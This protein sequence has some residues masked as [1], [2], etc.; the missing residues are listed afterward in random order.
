MQSNPLSEYLTMF[1]RLTALLI[2]GTMMTAC[3]DSST[4]PLSPNQASLGKGVSEPN[5]AV[6][7]SFRITTAGYSFTE[8]YTTVCDEATGQCTDL[9]S[10]HGQTG[11]AGNDKCVNGAL[12]KRSVKQGVVGEW[13]ATP[14]GVVPHPQCS[15]VV[16]VEGSTITVSFS[17][18]ANY[19][20]A[21]SKNIQLNFAPRCTIAEDLTSVCVP[22]YVHYSKAAGSTAGFG[23]LYGTG[24]DNSSWAIDLGVFTE[25]NNA[26]LL[27]R[28]ITLPAVE[29]NGLG[30]TGSA[31]FTW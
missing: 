26:S 25:P 14:T 31:T 15:D 30:R 12:Y 6:N 11:I 21:T 20:L 8:R 7:A 22:R 24:S 23:I 27:A 16:V 29:L 5:T 10:N 2:V 1:K 19:V 17:E 28:S 9:P 13:D 4:N 3:S 18:V